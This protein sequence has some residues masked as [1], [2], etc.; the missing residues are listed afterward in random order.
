MQLIAT[1]AGTACAAIGTDTRSVINCWGAND[2]GQATGRASPWSLRPTTVDT[3]PLGR[4]SQLA[5]GDGFACTITAITGL[6]RCW[7]D[8]PTLSDPDA[9]SSI[10]GIRALAIGARHACIAVGQSEGGLALLQCF[11]ENDRGQ[12]GFDSDGSRVVSVHAADNEAIAIQN[13]RGISAGT[14]HTCAWNAGQLW[15]W[16]ANDAGQLGRE[17]LPGLLESVAAPVQFRPNVGRIV[18]MS[19]GG[20]SGCA[21]VDVASSLAI[22]GGVDASL[23]DSP[24]PDAQVDAGDG[25]VLRQCNEAAPGNGLVFCWGAL[26]APLRSAQCNSDLPVLVRLASGQ[27]LSEAT[28]VF[29]GARHACA[30]V[31]ADRAVWCWGDSSAARMVGVMSSGALVAVPVPALDGALDLAI[32]GASSSLRAGAYLREREAFCA[33]FDRTRTPAQ[34][35]CW[36]P[37][38]LGQLGDPDRGRSVQDTLGD[39]RW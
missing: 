18:D 4:V 17:T 33:R 14:A 22:D 34:I 29:V 32:T 19:A 15:C 26:A 8:V 31:G 3:D 23:S 37:N 7:G 30:M 36:G 5:I 12:L 2:R 11:G 9:G 35:Q 38:D 24:S 28:R 39:V 20:E 13:F 25:A 27:R 1:G 21:V 16:G 6:L 10:A